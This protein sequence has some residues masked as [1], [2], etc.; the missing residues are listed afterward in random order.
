MTKF[1]SGLT[2]SKLPA[3]MSGTLALTLATFANAQQAHLPQAPA[4]AQATTKSGVARTAVQRPASPKSYGGAIQ[5]TH[6][7][8]PQPPVRGPVEIR[9]EFT[10]CVPSHLNEVLKCLSKPQWQ[11]P[12][13]PVT[14]ATRNPKDKKD[15][16]A[17]QVR[18]APASVNLTRLF[19]NRVPPKGTFRTQLVAALENTVREFETATQGR[20]YRA[21]EQSVGMLGAILATESRVTLARLVDRGT[22]SETK[23]FEKELVNKVRAE[24]ARA[25]GKIEG[26]QASP[27]EATVA[28]LQQTARKTAKGPEQSPTLF[29]G[30]VDGLG[31]IA[32]P[33]SAAAL[34]QLMQET[35]EIP[36]LNAV[37]VVANAAARVG[38]GLRSDAEFQVIR[39]SLI[40][41]FQAQQIQIGENDVNTLIRAYARTGERALNDLI[42]LLA[43]GGL[44][45]EQQSTAVSALVAA[46]THA[47]EGNTNQKV[48]QRE[49]QAEALLMII[50]DRV[51][52]ETLVLPLVGALRVLIPQTEKLSLAQKLMALALAA[53]DGAS[54][55]L[56]QQTIRLLA[57]TLDMKVDSGKWAYADHKTL[58]AGLNSLATAQVSGG[59]KAQKTL[60]SAQSK[61]FGALSAKV[62]SLP[63]NQ[64]VSENIE[65][66]NLAINESER[67][68]ALDGTSQKI[69]SG[70]AILVT[71]SN[72]QTL[73]L[74]IVSNDGDQLVEKAGEVF[75][76]VRE[77]VKSSGDADAIGAFESAVAELAKIHGSN[78]AFKKYVLN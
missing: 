51:S 77:G 75:Q 7:K 6:A 14:L 15:Q 1:R 47:Y 69:D 34:V 72:A 58:L 26:A 66:L 38:K 55:A 52:N 18:I 9:L 54:Q 29:K 24:A 67:W 63:E 40:Q 50:T 22:T 5:Q 23:R 61:L 48:T 33:E 13:N 11:S 41:G 3:L 8:K 73:V 30:A 59:S 65:L 19:A 28:L 20:N 36:G 44:S 42:T 16:K 64:Q 62:A 2:I 53:K 56:A 12:A 17:V 10:Q 60:L 57:E 76:R 31:S 45:P 68:L 70:L 32:R 4:K 46:I 71:A 49:E 25:L 35:R 39:G 37:P 43:V 74:E 27:N 78:P 21:A